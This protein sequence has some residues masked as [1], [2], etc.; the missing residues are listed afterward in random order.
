M[1]G[2]CLFR[3]ITVSRCIN[4]NPTTVLCPTAVLNR[5][6]T[7]GYAKKVAAKGKGKFMV[8]EELKGPEVCK[9]PV[10]L[11]TYAVGVNVFKQGED[12]VLKPPDQYPEWL[13]Q[14]NLGAVKKLHELDAD[15]W[16]Y[17]KRLRKENM[18]RFNRLHKGKKF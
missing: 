10:R 18:W 12:P 14:L 6:Q 2:S 4:T 7:C 17:W 1:S 11:T 13:F 15:T 16:E 5:V 9:D 8:K 3:I